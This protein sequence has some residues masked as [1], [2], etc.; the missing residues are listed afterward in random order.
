VPTG[1]D[2]LLV[3]SLGDEVSL[4]ATFRAN[5]ASLDE[6]LTR[7]DMIVLDGMNIELPSTSLRL[8]QIAHEAVVVAY[9]NRS[10]RSEIADLAR[11][12]EQVR[13]TV[14]GGILFS[15]RSGRSSGRKDKSAAAQAAPASSGSA[16]TSPAVTPGAASRSMT[17]TRSPCSD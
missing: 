8:G 12:L 16:A 4:G 17:S 14:L 6:V 15:R 3:L 11:H 2:G 1:I 7:V 9:K 13:A 10:R 5:G